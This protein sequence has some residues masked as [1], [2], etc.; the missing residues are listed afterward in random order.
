MKI[1]ALQKLTLLDYPGKMAAT[2]FTYGCNMRCPFCHNALLVTEESSGGIDAEEILSF[3]SKRKGMLEGVCVTGGEPLM[4]PDVEDFLRNIKDMGYSVKLDTNGTFP[5]KLKD[6]V[7]KGLVD[8]V[9]MD[10]K[11]CRDK[12]ALTAGKKLLDLSSIDESIR[13][14]LS[15]EVEAEFR[16]TV[17]KNFHEA[18]DLL[19][20]TDWIS[21]CD[22]YFLQQFVDSGNLID[23][24]LSGYSDDE[25]LTIYKQ[26]KRKLPVT[27]IR[28]ISEN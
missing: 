6:M 8:Y 3:L 26:V 7:R 11:N 21:G 10:I 2:V 4:Q 15:G 18:E 5:K 9:A 22:R 28:G 13:F 24:S 14:L 1:E 27:K 12:Y 16:T 20:I 19:K 25:L 17:V 23:P